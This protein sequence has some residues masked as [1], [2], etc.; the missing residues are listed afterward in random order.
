MEIFREL[1]ETGE[2]APVVGQTFGLSEVVAAMKR[3]QEG[4]VVGRAIITP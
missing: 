2:L 3:M 1:L 4:K